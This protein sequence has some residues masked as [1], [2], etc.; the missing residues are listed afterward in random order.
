MK[1]FVRETGTTKMDGP[2]SLAEIQEQFPAHPMLSNYE[3]HPAE[4]QSYRKLVRSTAWL[5]LLSVYDQQKPPEVESDFAEQGFAEPHDI[6]LKSD[7][8]TGLTV[9]AWIG[10]ICTPI[11]AVVVGTELS[12]F[13]GMELFLAGLVGG[14][15]LLGIAKVIEYLC[16]STQRLRRIENA[17]L[18]RD[19]APR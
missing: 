11:A 18:K 8:A 12:A 5:P 6:I 15:I 4:G 13:N 10:L 3:V 16:E 14:L 17:V 2:F 7:V 9:F 19:E 1:F